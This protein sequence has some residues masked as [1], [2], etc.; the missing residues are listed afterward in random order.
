MHGMMHSTSRVD[1]L[2][3]VPH[4]SLKLAH[5]LSLQVPKLSLDVAERALGVDEHR[6]FFSTERRASLKFKWPR[7]RAGLG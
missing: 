1:P 2:L 4:E 7:L 3:N 5:Y 6:T